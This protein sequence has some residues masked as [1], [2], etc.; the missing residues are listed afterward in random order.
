MV[1][2]GGRLGKGP[3]RTAHLRPVRMGLEHRLSKSN[4]GSSSRCKRLMEI[5]CVEN[6]IKKYQFIFQQL[7]LVYN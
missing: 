6:N 4:M 1:T 5:I 3:M 7:Y 2:I